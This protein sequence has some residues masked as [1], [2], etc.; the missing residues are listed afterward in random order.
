MRNEAINKIVIDAIKILV[1]GF[2]W[3]GF[4][5]SFLPPKGMSCINIPSN[6]FALLLCFTVTAC[7]ETLSG[8]TDNYN[9]SEGIKN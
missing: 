5:A 7:F 1:F 6:G 3:A 9:V 8:F 2:S 4:T